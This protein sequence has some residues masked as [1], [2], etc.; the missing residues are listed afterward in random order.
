MKN[1][2]FTFLELV[3]AVVIIVILIAVS[4]P[5]FLEL[6]ES[7]RE[8][9]TR[10][11]LGT[12]RSVVAIMYAKNIAEDRKEYPQFLSPSDFAE[13]GIPVNRLNGK[14]EIR[15]VTEDVAEAFPKSSVYGWW[16]NTKNGRVGAYSD[17]K[18]DTSS[19]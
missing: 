17:G 13:K 18:T 1:K 16:Y 5:R 8:T 10:S 9:A 19:W 4:L 2:G 11:G 15:Y 6:S 3:L 12:I 14:G 7:A